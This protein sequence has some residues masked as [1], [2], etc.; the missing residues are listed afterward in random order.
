MDPIIGAGIG[1]L[2]SA[3]PGIYG[4][5]QAAKYQQRAAKQNSKLATR[6][7]LVQL[8][9]QEPTRNLG[10]QAQGDIASALG[11]SLP[12]YSTVDQLQ[13]S[14]NPLKSSTVKKQLKQG[15][16]ID[17]L[18]QMGTLDLNG[19]SISRLTKAGVPFESI[20]RLA[21]R[22]QATGT[23]PAVPVASSTTGTPQQDFSRFYDSPDYQF[24]QSEGMKGIGNSFAARGGAT[25]GNALRALSEFNSNLAAGEYNNWFN[26]RLG[27]ANN[28]Q[29]AANNVGTATTGTVNSLMGSNTQA[30]DARA[31]GVL[32]SSGAVIGALQGLGSF[33]GNYYGSQA[34]QS[35]QLSQYG[36]YA[37]GYKSPNQMYVGGDISPWMRY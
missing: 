25:G 37:S 17:Q 10:Y 21:G 30:G 32:G 4:S 14:L 20:M 12:A 23:A 35:P 34:Q 18:A 7:Q 33:A 11:Y 16:S 24:R 29:T 6:N 15:M 22:G 8:N 3:G 27:L 5:Q 13:T 19:K 31:S 2:V 28:G 26:R 9:L 1:S 36:P